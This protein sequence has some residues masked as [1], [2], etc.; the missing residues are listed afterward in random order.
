MVI[1]PPLMAIYFNGKNNDEPLDG[2]R[3]PIA[4]QTQERAGSLGLAPHP[5]RCSTAVYIYIYKLYTYC[6][7]GRLGGCPK[8]PQLQV[9]LQNPLWVWMCRFAC[10]HRH[11]YI[12]SPSLSLSLSLALSLSRSL[13]LARS[14]SL[15]P[16]RSGLP[17]MKACTY[18]ATSILCP[19]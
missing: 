7:V 19:W 4:T 2:M 5:T 12:Y 13:S 14:L 16:S 9:G 18:G 11:I 3:Y 17:A 10:M 15:S 8:L 6:Y 1:H